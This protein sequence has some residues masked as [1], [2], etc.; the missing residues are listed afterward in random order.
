MLHSDPIARASLDEVLNHPWMK[1][2]FKRS[3]YDT[4]LVGADV[5]MHSHAELRWPDKVD[6]KTFNRIA[7]LESRNRDDAWKGLTNALGLVSS[8]LC[9]ARTGRG[10]GVDSRGQLPELTSASN[11]GRLVRGLRE[12]PDR[13]WPLLAKVRSCAVLEWPALIHP[14]T[15]WTFDDAPRKAADK[16]DSKHPQF[17]RPCRWMRWRYH[18]TKAL[19]ESAESASSTFLTKGWE[20]DVADGPLF[21]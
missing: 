1:P 7:A 2:A 13:V 8:H 9:E 15:S 12:F 11:V 17:P 21:T 10:G 18:Q 19:R 6:R 5:P 4:L 3:N 16:L 20:S 14:G